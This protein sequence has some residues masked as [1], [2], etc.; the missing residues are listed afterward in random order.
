MVDFPLGIHTNPRFH[1]KES[2]KTNHSMTS[3]HYGQLQTLDFQSNINPNQNSN[4]NNLTQISN[5]QIVI[6]HQRFF[7]STK[8]QTPKP[9]NFTNTIILER[10]TLTRAC[11]QTLGFMTTNKQVSSYIQDFII[12]H[13]HFIS[14]VSQTQL[15][16]YQ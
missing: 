6:I 12:M 1:T 9:Q 13:R 10:Q 3:F 8:V 14:Y 16:K 15:H 5:H 4:F 11:F 7:T 2:I